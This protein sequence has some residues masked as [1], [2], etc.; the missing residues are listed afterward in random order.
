MERKRLSFDLVRATCVL[1][2][3]CVTFIDLPIP[4]ERNPPNARWLKWLER[5]FTARNVR[6]SNPTSASRLPLSRLGQPGS[7]SA[8]VLPSVGMA[9]RHQKGPTAERFILLSLY[10]VY[11]VI[12]YSKPCPVLNIEFKPDSYVGGMVTN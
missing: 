6:D 2:Y 5:E 8:L 10:C 9:A 1:C 12:I 4:I 11:G 7:I 3:L